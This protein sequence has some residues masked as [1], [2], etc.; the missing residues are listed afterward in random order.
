MVGMIKGMG[1]HSQAFVLGYY[2]SSFDF[3]VGFA[4]DFG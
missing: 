2:G 3:L 4:R 1:W